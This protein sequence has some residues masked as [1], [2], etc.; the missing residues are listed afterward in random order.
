MKTFLL[1]IIFVLLTVMPSG[2][3]MTNTHVK[4]YEEGQLVKECD[5][6]YS[7]LWKDLTKAEA[8]V[9]GG[10]GSIEQSTPNAQAMGQMMQMFQLFKSMMAPTVVP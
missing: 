1:S 7:N 8:D 9:C 10:K 3:A 2:C 4:V 5:F 6:T